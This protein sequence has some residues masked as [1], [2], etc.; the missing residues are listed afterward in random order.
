MGDFIKSAFGYFGGP[1]PSNK[2]N[3]LVGQS[4][5]VGKTTLRIR[6]V[7]AEGRSFH[8]KMSIAI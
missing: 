3:E 1:S 8:K 2:E 4:I 5:E 7:I 6:R